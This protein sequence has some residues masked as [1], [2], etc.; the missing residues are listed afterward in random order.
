MTSIRHPRFPVA[1]GLVLLL[2]IALVS[3]D[4]PAPQ[5]GPKTA[6]SAPG[7][8]G[9]CGTLASRFARCPAEDQGTSL[10]SCGHDQRCMESLLRPAAVAGIEACVRRLPCGQGPRAG[11]ACVR[12]EAD[13]APRTAERT[14]VREAC[15][16]RAAGC[17]EKLEA[18][19]QFIPLMHDSVRKRVGTCL[20]YLTCSDVD[21]CIEQVYEAWGCP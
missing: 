9:L 2:W 6:R 1:S 3:C 19:C 7:P 20:E 11:V 21:R 16:R 17:G 4:S 10:N 14:Q 12:Q 15:T 18:T 5:R 8:T 13:R